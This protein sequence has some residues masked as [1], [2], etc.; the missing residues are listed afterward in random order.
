MTVL[1][2]DRKSGLILNDN[3]ELVDSFLTD[4]DHDNVNG[5]ELHFMGD[6]ST[7]LVIRNNGE[8]APKDEA[9]SIGWHRTDEQPCRANYNGMRELD[10]EDNWRPSFDWTALGHIKLN[11]STETDGSVEGRCTGPYDFM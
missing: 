9:E 3:Y 4:W 10:G 2:R 5:H 11:E 7:V 1:D 8:D 6:G